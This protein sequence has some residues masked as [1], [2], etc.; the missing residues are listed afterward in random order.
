MAEPTDADREKAENTGMQSKET[1]DATLLAHELNEK[2]PGFSCVNGEGDRY[3]WI[4]VSRYLNEKFNLA[5]ASERQAAEERQRA[6]DIEIVKSFGAID[7]EEHGVG[8]IASAIR[9][10]G[11]GSQ[12][13]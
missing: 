4:T 5:L 2:F 11:V 13:G 7:V 8:I 10:T 1:E 3:D 6:K 9:A 12:N